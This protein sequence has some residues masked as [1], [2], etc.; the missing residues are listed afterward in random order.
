GG[1]L[2]EQVGGSEERGI[3]VGGRCRHQRGRRRLRTATQL[4]YRR[5]RGHPY[6]LSVLRTGALGPRSVASRDTRL[7]AT[8]LMAQDSTPTA[9]RLPRAFRRRKSA[10]IRRSRRQN[11]GG[12]F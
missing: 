5:G 8:P 10:I 4:G 7:A 6:P 1:A 11:E 2:L 9:D 3:L 12:P